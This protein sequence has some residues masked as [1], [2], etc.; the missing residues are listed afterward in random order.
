MRPHEPLKE[1]SDRRHFSSQP[2]QTPTSVP[3]SS[4]STPLFSDIAHGLASSG[5]NSNA[6]IATPVGTARRSRRR[7]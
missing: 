3:A 5:G 4:R 7:K 6:A 2:N 1:G